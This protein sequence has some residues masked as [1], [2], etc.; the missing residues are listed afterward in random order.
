M[1]T[2]KREFRLAFM[3]NKLQVSNFTSK[4]ISNKVIRI[5]EIREIAVSAPT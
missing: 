1:G 3:I 4:F 5:S 2:K